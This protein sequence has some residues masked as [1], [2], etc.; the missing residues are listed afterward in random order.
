MPDARFPRFRRSLDL[1]RSDNEKEPLQNGSFFYI[2]FDTVAISLEIC[3]NGLKML[4]F[5]ECL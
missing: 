3:Y 4:S 2:F 5:F 1:S